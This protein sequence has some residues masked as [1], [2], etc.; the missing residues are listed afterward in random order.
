[1]GDGCK[2]CTQN[3]QHLSELML[4]LFVVSANCRHNEFV[5]YEFANSLKIVSCWKQQKAIG[6]IYIVMGGAVFLVV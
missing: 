1:M 2:F 4:D 6:K 3:K 5:Y